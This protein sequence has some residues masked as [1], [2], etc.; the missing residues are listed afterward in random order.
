MRSVLR[1][2]TVGV[3]SS[4][5]RSPNSGCMISSMRYVQVYRLLPGTVGHYRWHPRRG[6][7]CWRVQ[8]RSPVDHHRSGRLSLERQAE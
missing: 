4:I 1:Y 6:W 2:D 8:R 3:W 7:R 5:A